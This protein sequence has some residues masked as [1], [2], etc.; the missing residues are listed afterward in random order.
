M[1]VVDFPS[2]IFQLVDEGRARLYK[3]DGFGVWVGQSHIP[4]TQTG[5]DIAADLDRA[6]LDGTNWAVFQEAD[7]IIVDGFWS[8]A[9][10]VGHG[11]QQDGV[12]CEQRGHFGWAFSG[13]SRIELREQA[14]DLG[15]GRVSAL[16][17]AS[18]GLCR[19][20]SNGDHGREG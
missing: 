8:R 13:P 15:W 7:E 16:H 20:C 17:F 14:S 2:A 19:S 5:C 6:G 11:R 3:G 4:R 10:G 9:R 1:Q 18:A 12:L